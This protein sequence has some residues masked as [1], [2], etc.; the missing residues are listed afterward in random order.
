MLKFAKGLYMVSGIYGLLVLL[1]QY[2]LESRNG[3]NFPPAINHPEY[4]YGFIGVAVAWQIGFLII[5]RD[6]Q[7]YGPLMIAGVI[8]KYSYGCAVLVL[9]G[10]GRLAGLMLVTGLIDLA[11]GTLF[12]VAYQKVG[13]SK[14]TMRDSQ[15]YEEYSSCSAITER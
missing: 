4:Y 2:F 12:A 5:A 9:Y 13:R 3:M 15:F 11:L 6:P 8:E 7:R 1:P 10:Q 14:K